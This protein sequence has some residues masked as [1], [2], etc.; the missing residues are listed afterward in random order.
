MMAENSRGLLRLI[1]NFKDVEVV[2]A[3]RLGGQMVS[4]YKTI[5]PEASTSEAQ[6]VF[7]MAQG[8]IG[9]TAV[10]MTSQSAPEFLLID[11]FT[12]SSERGLP[13]K[14]CGPDY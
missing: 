1:E 8:Q 7:D 4:S 13:S 2:Y 14:N 3:E 10:G 9:F 12:V 6:A 11:C 5:I